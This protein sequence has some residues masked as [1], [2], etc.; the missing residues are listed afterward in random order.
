MVELV[1]VAWESALR[2]TVV[3]CLNGVHSNYEGERSTFS[4]YDEGSYLNLEA[5]GDVIIF[6]VIRRVDRTFPV[7]DDFMSRDSR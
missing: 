5:R 1:S 3:W 7:G 4:C 2:W 6:D